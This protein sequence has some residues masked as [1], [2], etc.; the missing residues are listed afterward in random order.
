MFAMPLALSLR[1]FTREDLPTV[2]PWFRDPDTRRFLGDPTW[3][4]VM[5][6]R[7]DRIVGKEF[8]G[9]IQTAAFRYLAHAEGRPFGYVDCGTFDRCTV[10]GGE[11]PDGPT[12]IE[13]IDVATG[14]IAFVVA[15]EVRGEGLG[16]AMIRALISQPELE[17]VELFEAGVEPDNTASRRCLEAAGFR[18]RSKD[19]DFEGT[20][21]YRAWRRTRTGSRRA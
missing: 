15:P 5:L 1:A 4:A 17:F 20:L 18:L 6:E 13:S 16:R 19:P 3:P 7:G 21:Y 12:I 14:S 11:G 2:E 10:Y 8:R 9:A